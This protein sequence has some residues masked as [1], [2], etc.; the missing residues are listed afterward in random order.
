MLVM[1]VGQFVSVTAPVKFEMR[2]PSRGLGRGLLVAGGVPLR[3]EVEELCGESPSSE[4]GVGVFVA[5][6]D[7]I[8]VVGCRSFDSESPVASGGVSVVED[9]GVSP[10]SSGPS[11]R[12][13][14]RRCS[15]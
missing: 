2:D 13:S 12:R 4:V 10:E 1:N 15:W 3:A 5:D 11:C 14:S 7:S 6:T 8:E 9:G